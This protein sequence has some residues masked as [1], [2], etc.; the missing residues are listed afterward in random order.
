MFAGL[1]VVVV[2]FA[3]TWIAVAPK[4]EAPR[5]MG[6]VPTAA[7][8]AWHRCETNLFLHFG[9]NT[10]TDRE[11]GTGKEDPNIFN[12]ARLDARPFDT[13]AAR[14]PCAASQDSRGERHCVL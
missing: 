13:R 4:F 3:C 10:F 12:P 2:I 5:S 6:A 8:I 11:W 1:K 9:V 7:Q 14:S